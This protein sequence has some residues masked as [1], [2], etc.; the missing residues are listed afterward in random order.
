MCGIPS[1]LSLIL[2]CSP[3]D[4]LLI[5]LGICWLTGSTTMS[6]HCS[7]CMGWQQTVYVD[8]AVCRLADL[9]NSSDS[10]FGAGWFRA[11]ASKRRLWSTIIVFMAAIC[12]S[13][14]KIDFPL[15]LFSLECVGI[16]PCPCG[17]YTGV[18]D[19]LFPSDFLLLRFR[20]CTCS[21]LH[22]HAAHEHTLVTS[23]Y[24]WLLQFSFWLIFFIL[25]R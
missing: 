7:G 17:M 19:F 14:V 18:R 6:R 23:Y 12:A 10:L 9:V 13:C 3:V 11:D 20:V 4:E 1:N 2:V 16:F 15:C 22:F 8:V 24:V 25:S 21:S 5:L